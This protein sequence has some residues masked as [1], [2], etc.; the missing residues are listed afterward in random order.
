MGQRPV[1]PDVMKKFYGSGQWRETDY[2]DFISLVKRRGLDPALETTELMKGHDVR[3]GGV[4]Y[5]LASLVPQPN[6]AVPEKREKR[7]PA[8]NSPADERDRSQTTLF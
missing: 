2:F 5:R 4:V 1:Y 7:G 6:A 8:E 3:L